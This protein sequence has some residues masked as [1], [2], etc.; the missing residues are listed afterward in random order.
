MN[1]ECS[2]VVASRWFQLSVILLH[3]NYCTKK[4]WELGFNFFQQ[5]T[6]HICASSAEAVTA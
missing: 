4:G 2:E 3:Q 5:E 6:R 1:E